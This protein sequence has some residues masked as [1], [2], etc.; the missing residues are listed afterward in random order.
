[1][2]L[3]VI[4]TV[5]FII[6]VFV[7][8]LLIYTIRTLR[9]PNRKKIQ[10]RLSALSSYR[11]RDESIDIVRKR[12]LSDVPSLN[13][14]LPSMPGIQWLNRLVLQSK[15]SY[16]PGFFILLSIVL[17][18]TCFLLSNFIIKDFVLSILIAALA[19]WTPFFYLK[20]KRKRRMEKFERQL[21][22]GLD[23]IARSL[24]AGHAFIS[25]MRMVADEFDD[26]LGTE[27][28]ETLEEI[29]LG[30]SVPDALKDLPNRVSCDEIRY[31]VVAVIL[32]RESGGN[33]AEVV[34]SLANV[35]RERF[36][37]HGKIR[38]LSAEGKLSAGVLIAIPFFVAIVF[39]FLRPEYLKPL[40]TEFVGRIILGVAGFMMLMGIMVI[41]KM[42]RIE[43]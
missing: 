21:P 36:K 5:I 39:F 42:I 20:R 15:V 1:M 13:K 14:I 10:K 23:L 33:L 26:P 38:T 22:D 41:R 32:Q 24:K 37:F 11:L 27:F 4:G 43:V 28:E 34:E 6:T 7:I 2:S 12:V 3:F 19:G 16:P 9:N 25:G 30:A 17:L 31:F 18:L 8:E 40:Y 29:N 35:I